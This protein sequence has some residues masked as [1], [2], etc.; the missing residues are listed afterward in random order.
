MRAQRKGKLL[1]AFEYLAG[2]DPDFL[3]AYN[4]LAVLNFSYPPAAGSRALEPK[5]QELIAI[6]LLASVHG[7]TTRHHIRRA[8]ELGATEREIVEALEM[9][10]QITGAAGMEFGLSQLMALKAESSQSR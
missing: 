6:A 1:P 4:N 2:V 10:L 7:E 3:E 9:T 8:L 5:I